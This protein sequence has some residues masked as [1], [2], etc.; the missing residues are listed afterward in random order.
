VRDCPVC[1]L[2]VRVSY[3][4]LGGEGVSCLCVASGAWCLVQVDKPLPTMGIVGHMVGLVLVVV[5]AGARPLVSCRDARLGCFQWI[6]Q[7]G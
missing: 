4:P 1:W 3:V 2:C 7:R 6:Q 5:V